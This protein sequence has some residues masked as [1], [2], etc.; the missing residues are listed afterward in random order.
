MDQKKLLDSVKLNEST[1]STVL[2]AL[3]IVVT[4]G[5][6]VNYWRASRKAN[7]AAV[8]TT[9]IENIEGQTKLA[10]PTLGE[11][12]KAAELPAK[13]VVAKGEYLWQISTKYYGYGYNWVDIAKANKLAKPFAVKA[14]QE[15]VIP[16]VRVRIPV[17]K[18][19]VMTNVAAKVALPS[20]IM[21]GSAIS[22]NSYVVVKGDHLWNIAVRAYGDGYKWGAIAKANK[23][24]NPGLIYSGTKLALPR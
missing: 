18:R 19:A 2:G 15:L 21:I 7:V 23:I 22:G 9:A 8:P 24:K 3:V 20:K 16:S 12:M 1:I 5:L 14:G 4:I 10:L 17:A 13:H 11:T 6:I